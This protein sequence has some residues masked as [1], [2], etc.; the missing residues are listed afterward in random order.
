MNSSIPSGMDFSI[1]VK[2]KLRRT[3]SEFVVL[4]ALSG[5]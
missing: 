3:S 1:A 2:K 4:K 5:V